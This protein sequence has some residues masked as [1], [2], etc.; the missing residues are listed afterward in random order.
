MGIT[1]DQASHV[2]TARIK[3]LIGKN[4]CLVL[5]GNSKS[6]YGKVKEITQL[7]E[8]ILSLKED[9]IPFYCHVSNIAGVK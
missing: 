9:N 7:N 6:V 1:E 4:V 2:V 3:T 8:V 5:K